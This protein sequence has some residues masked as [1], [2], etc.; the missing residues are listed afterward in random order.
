MH[1]SIHILTHSKSIVSLSNRFA[2]HLILYAYSKRNTFRF[3]ILN[4]SGG[5]IE[6]DSN[7]VMSGGALT[8]QTSLKFN[9]H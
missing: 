2:F 4:T 1:I 6:L 9:I 8:S 5:R 3:S 7:Y